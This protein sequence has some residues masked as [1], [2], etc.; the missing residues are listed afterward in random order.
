MIRKVYSKPSIEIVYCKMASLLA[1]LSSWEPED[2]PGGGG[3]F[4]YEDEDDD[5]FGGGT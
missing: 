1:S 2:D 4:G 3:G 5:E